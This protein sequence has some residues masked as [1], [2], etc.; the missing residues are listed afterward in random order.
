MGDELSEGDIL[1]VEEIHVEDSYRRQNL[2]RCLVSLIFDKTASKCAYPSRKAAHMFDFVDEEP[3]V[4]LPWL[5]QK[6]RP[7]Q[8]SGMPTAFR[9]VAAT[10]WF[11]KA[12]NNT[13]PHH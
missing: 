9:R 5:G 13:H 1:L 7:Q 2:A 12:G 11:C 4:R 8:L 3:V 10:H 6:T